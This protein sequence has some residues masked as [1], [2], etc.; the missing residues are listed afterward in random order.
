MDLVKLCENECRSSSFDIN[1]AL[2]RV[3]L[4]Q[5]DLRK[6]RKLAENDDAVPRKLKDCFVSVTNL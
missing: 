3:N 1:D 6:L 5:D 4:T 2:K